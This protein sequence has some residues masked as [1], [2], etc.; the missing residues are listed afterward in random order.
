MRAGSCAAKCVAH[1]SIISPAPMNSTFW[2][3]RRRENPRREL[4]RR[5]RHRYAVGADL[6]RAAH[7]LG[8][9]ERALEQLAEHRA[10]RAGGLRRARRLLHLAEDLAAR[11]A[12]SN[13]GPRRRG[14]RAAPPARA[15]ACRGRATVRRHRRGGS[16]RAT[17]WR[18]RAWPGRVRPERYS[19]VRLQVE[20]IAAS[21]ASRRFASPSASPRRST[22]NTTRSRTPSGA[23]WW[24]SPR[25]TMDMRW[26]MTLR[27]EIISAFPGPD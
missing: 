4:H 19:S 15:A 27:P 6:R 9:R 13:P 26:K 12:P 21:G 7:F 20:R 5:G 16:W 24:F 25:A 18:R 2:S 11:P 8:D 22:W 23:V 17:R 10:E 3:F 1:S 14:M